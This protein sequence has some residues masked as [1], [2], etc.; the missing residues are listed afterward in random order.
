[1]TQAAQGIAYGSTARFIP[2]SADEPWHKIVVLQRCFLTYVA[3]DIFTIMNARWRR[4]LIVLVLNRTSIEC[5]Y[6][7]PRGRLESGK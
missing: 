2:S 6:D 4:L 3:T 1:M 7:V 5:N